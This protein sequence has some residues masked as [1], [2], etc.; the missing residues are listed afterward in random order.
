MFVYFLFDCTI[1]ILGF[2]FLILKILFFLQEKYLGLGNYYLCSSSTSC[3][4]S[5]VCQTSANAITLS[6]AI[7]WNYY[8]VS[9]RHVLIVLCPVYVLHR[10]LLLITVT[11]TTILQ[12]SHIG[13]ELCPSRWQSQALTTKLT[14]LMVIRILRLIMLKTCYLLGKFESVNGFH[15]FCWYYVFAIVVGLL[16]VNCVEVFV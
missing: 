6:Y 13:F 8:R 7:F 1:R 14:P 12:L 15:L 2:L 4:V 3:L 10:L 9:M 16:A 5:N 11:V